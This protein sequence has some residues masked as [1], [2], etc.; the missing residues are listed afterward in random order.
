MA[1]SVAAVGTHALA[2]TTDGKEMVHREGNVSRKDSGYASATLARLQTAWGDRISE[3]AADK[4]LH[5]F[6]YMFI[7]Y[8]HV[9]PFLVLFVVLKQLRFDSLAN[10][11][12][13]IS[14]TIRL[15]C[16]LIAF[17]YGKEAGIDITR[18]TACPTVPGGE[19]KRLRTG[20]ACTPCVM[21][22]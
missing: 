20:P 7:G 12:L 22:I 6:E 15:S 18:I 9:M 10:T 14:V 19:L 11:G 3:N 13:A 16:F 8:A 4:L 2:V 5:F 21:R 1:G 17:R